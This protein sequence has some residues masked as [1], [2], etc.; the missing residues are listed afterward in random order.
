MADALDEP[1]CLKPTD[2]ALKVLAKVAP[3]AELLQTLD[4]RASADAAPSADGEPPPEAV[5]LSSDVVWD[6]ARRLAESSYFRVLSDIPLGELRKDALRRLDLRNQRL[7][8]AEGVVVGVALEKIAH[9]RGSKWSLTS[10]DLRG[11]WL[12]LQAAKA[13]EPVVPQ[14]QTLSSI[15]L[16]PL[17]ESQQLLG[18][19]RGLGTF[20]V[21]CLAAL[22]IPHN[23]TAMDLRGNPIGKDG[24]EALVPAAEH[25]KQLSKI[26]LA[27]IA[28]GAIDKLDLSGPTGEGLDL[29]DFEVRVLCGVLEKYPNLRELNLRGNPITDKGVERLQGMCQK[30]ESLE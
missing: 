12:G 14:L 9:E 4:L 15:A 3:S 10:V 5:D 21:A 23:I 7:G 27:Q 24:A 6:F 20:E 30:V 22:V 11:N 18:T 13:F 25:L 17:F 26:P 19:G 16:K 8:E 29:G 1:P 28:E 2:D